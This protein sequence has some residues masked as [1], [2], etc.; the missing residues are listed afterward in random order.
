MAPSTPTLTHNFTADESWESQ[1]VCLFGII[2][3]VLLY[4]LCCHLY[5]SAMGSAATSAGDLDR[6]LV[7]YGKG[8]IRTSGRAGADI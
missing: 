7:P 5:S 3:F 6:I 1:L 8:N 2:A 4:T